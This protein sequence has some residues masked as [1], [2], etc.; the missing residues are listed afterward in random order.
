MLAAVEPVSDAAAL[1]EL[2]LQ[3]HRAGAVDAAVD[4]YGR[5]LAASPKHLGALTNHGVLMASL[6]RFDEALE[7]YRDAQELSPNDPDLLTNIGNLFLNRG[8]P[9]EAEAC[10]RQALRANPAAAAAA[11]GLVEA[12]AAAERNEEAID[13]GLAQLR[14]APESV[15]LAVRVASIQLLTGDLAGAKMLIADAVSRA[16]ANAQALCLM[17]EVS[18]QRGDLAQAVE[19]LKKAVAADPAWVRPCHRLAVTYQEA[20]DYAGALKM[21]L[22]GIRRGP[23]AGLLRDYGEFLR[24]GGKA[25]DAQV[26]LDKSWELDP[27]DWRT[28]LHLGN[29]HYAA[30]NNDEALQWFRIAAGLEDGVFEPRV[31][32]GLTLHRMGRNDEALAV[33]IALDRDFPREPDVLLALGHTW[34]VRGVLERAEAVYRA[35]IAAAPDRTD[36]KLHLASACVEGTGQEEAMRLAQEALATEPENLF[37]LNILSRALSNMGRHEQAVE[38]A[39]RAMACASADDVGTIMAQASVLERAKHRVAALAAYRLA[40]SVNADNFLALARSFD[41]Q[42]TLCDWTTYDAYIADIL[43]SVEDSV[44]EKKPLKLCVH[45]LQNIPISWDLL[46]RAA[47][48]AAELVDESTALARAK[49]KY[50]FD[51]RL[52]RWRNGERRRIRIGFALPYTFFHSFPMLMRAITERIDR[53]RFEVYGYSVRPGDSAFDREYRATF[54]EFRDVPYAAPDAAAEIIHNDDIDILIDVTGHTSINCQGLMSFRP[55]PAQVHMLGYGITTGARYIDYLVT[56][57]TWLRPEYRPGCTEDVV[58][59][60][61]NW[62]VG[63][64]NEKSDRTFRRK[65]FGLPEDGFVFCNFNQPFKIEPTIFEVWMRILK[66]VPGSV[67]WFGDWDKATRQN[68]VREAAARGIDGARLVF[69]PIFS[70]PDHLARLPLADMAFDNRYQGGGATTLDVLW[71]GVPI[72]TCPGDLPTSGNGLTLATALGVPEMAVDTLD[73]YEE[74]AVAMATDPEAYRALRDK[75]QDN[76]DTH[77]L[78]DCDRYTRHFERAMEMIWEQTVAGERGDLTVPPIS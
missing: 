65:E 15:Q 25:A 3:Q 48:R 53:S 62:L 41:L 40:L 61:D 9:G 24:T 14:R 55:A 11:L 46:S 43:H 32:E 68:L 72:V 28:A 76:R 74:F 12:L 5:V 39:N 73:D 6:G 57:G 4:L 66:R 34:Y 59:L 45:D 35:A 7:S 13:A 37:A 8:E 44:A 49:V 20:K 2:A 1:F 67:I 77:P 38:A 51:D 29:L 69:S 16:P 27:S 18:I 23:T 30:E 71:A 63:Y 56:D 10:Y 78:F 22:E 52:E 64:R 17:G 70:L 50:T 36:I 26:A 19:M 33:L 47:R 58:Y 60:P 31:N 21:F 42:L 54:D 75:V